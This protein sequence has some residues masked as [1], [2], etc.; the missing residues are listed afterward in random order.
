MKMTA[1]LPDILAN[2][3]IGQYIFGDVRNCTYGTLEFC[4]IAEGLLQKKLI[5]E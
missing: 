1:T 3:T 4:W 5:I 2:I